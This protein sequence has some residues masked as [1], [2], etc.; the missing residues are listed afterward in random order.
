MINC[1]HLFKKSKICAFT[2]Q[3]FNLDELNELER[4]LS[5]TQ[6]TSHFHPKRREEFLLGRLAAKRA[7]L[8]CTGTELKELPVGDKRQPL[9]PNGV[10]G[11]IT[12]SQTTILAAV[13]L[14]EICTGVGIDLEFKNRVTPELTRMIFTDKDHALEHAMED[15]LYRALV[16]SAKESLYKA[17]FPTVQLFFGF[18]TAALT[19]LDE[20]Q[21]QF[22]IT[23][24]KDLHPLYRTHREIDGR[25]HFTNTEIL[26]VIE[27]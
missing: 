16:F 17:L 3:D 20:K 24:Q 4:Q 21:G 23:L 6:I 22:T 14:K 26:T 7:Y 18:E 5:L 13:A 8:A 11:S 25:F 10:V 12:H 9:W 15:G 2:R 19:G 1:A 27:L